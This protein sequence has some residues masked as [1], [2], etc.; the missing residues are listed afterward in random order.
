MPE[1]HHRLDD[2]GVIGLQAEAGDERPVDLDRF[3]REVAQI[4]G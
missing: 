4:V 1:P 3:D 2:R